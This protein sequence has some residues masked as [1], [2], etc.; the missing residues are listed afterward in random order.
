MGIL[1]R[2]KRINKNLVMIDGFLLL[3]QKDGL[4]GDSINR[5]NVLLMTKLNDFLILEN[6][7]NEGMFYTF[8]NK[9]LEEVKIKGQLCLEH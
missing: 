6:M 5:E 1:K 2:T 8:I 3:K 4:Y 7:T 9:I